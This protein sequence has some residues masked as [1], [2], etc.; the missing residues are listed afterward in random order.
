MGDDW[1]GLGNRS[2]LTAREQ[3]VS[4]QGLLDLAA[5]YPQ[6]SVPRWLADLHRTAG[7]AHLTNRYLQRFP[8]LRRGPYQR[9]PSPVDLEENLVSAVLEFLR[10][11]AALSTNCF[12]TF[13]GSVAIERALSIAVPPGGA[14][15]IQAPIFD[16]IPG[17]LRERGV[18]PDWWELRWS[19]PTWDPAGTHLDG[20]DATVVVTPDNPSGAT[21]TAAALHKLVGA[22]KAAGCT[23]VVDQSFAL[24]SRDGRAAPL[25]PTVADPAG[26]WIMIWDTGKTFDLYGE[27]IG[28][29]VVGDALR[30]RARLALGLVQYALASTLMM[31]MTQILRAASRNGYLD[32]LA[33]LRRT[34]EE[35]LTQRCG[36][37]LAVLRTAPFGAFTLLDPSAVD[38][39]TAVER[40]ERLGLGLL[41][42]E[43]F[44]RGTP[45]AGRQQP[46][47]RIPLL[48]RPAVMRQAL[49]LLSAALSASAPTVPLGREIPRPAVRCRHR[50]D[51]H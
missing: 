20:V 17:F 30:E 4:R 37:G 8:H 44:T 27:K 31:R 22:A 45:L 51:H 7:P 19:D 1:T 29:L 16:V 9:T 5:G 24:L 28:V 46:M 18:R 38:A 47:L 34:N 42:T 26:S 35:L 23:V 32:S 3:Q 12:V 25:L 36:E 2:Q 6:L 40:A 14:V 13:S 43:S 48:R 21:A 10:L 49:G 11:P 39:D 50:L 41:S 33:G 15:R